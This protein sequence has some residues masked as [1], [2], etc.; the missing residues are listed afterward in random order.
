M[1]HLISSPTATLNMHVRCS[2]HLIYLIIHATNV[3]LEFSN[4]LLHVICVIHTT[5]FT[6][7][8][9]ICHLVTLF[10]LRNLFQFF[11]FFLFFRTST[12]ISLLPHAL[13][14]QR[15]LLVLIFIPSHV[16]ILFCTLFLHFHF[17][18][19]QLFSSFRYY[20]TNN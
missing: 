11:L 14:T 9:V 13:Y 1:T 4:N 20:A 5:P 3:L 8:L 12:P 19:I 18:L 15:L 2:I 10:P 17:R 6:T 16:K 7:N